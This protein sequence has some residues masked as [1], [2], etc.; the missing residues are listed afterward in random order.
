MAA[1]KK[2]SVARFNIEGKTY[3]IDQDTL[4]WGEV[5]ELE[6]YFDKS[7]EEVNLNSGRGAMFLAYLA[8][9]RVEPNTTLDDLRALPVTAIEPAK[10]A[11]PTEPPRDSGGGRSS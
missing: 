3:E 6:V 5:E 2:A 1:R 11:R 8:K 10:P 4:T 7:A 9:R